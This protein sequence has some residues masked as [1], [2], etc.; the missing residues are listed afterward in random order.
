MNSL[1]ERLHSSDDLP[2]TSLS[3]VLPPPNFE[4]NLLSPS[5]QSVYEPDVLHPAFHR[6]GRS[7]VTSAPSPPVP[8]PLQMIK[9]TPVLLPAPLAPQRPEESALTLTRA[10][11][12]PSTN[13]H[14]PAPTLLSPSLLGRPCK[15]NDYWGFCKGAW[16]IRNDATKGM[17]LTT[18][19]G[20]QG[21][22]NKVSVFQCRHCDF[23]SDPVTIKPYAIDSS[24]YVS[25]AGTMY[26]WIFLAKSH[27]RYNSGGSRLQS[28]SSSSV[29]SASSSSRHSVGAGYRYG[30]LF[31]SEK[32][33]IAVKFNSV[34]DMMAHIVK[35]HGE[36]MG[37]KVVQLRTRCV[38][39][40][41][42]STSEDFD[43]CVPDGAGPGDKKPEPVQA[44]ADL[45]VLK[46]S[47][48]VSDWKS[49]Y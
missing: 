21:P 36:M 6:R 28:S 19:P 14:L 40:R 25:S 46:R 27:I 16:D 49:S 11:S 44:E 30:C 1:P 17:R 37:N 43:I 45:R 3:L 47:M 38:Y 31:C 12:I 42:A 4:P 48:L 24:V 41:L 2:P 26:R 39:G 9:P 33:R 10:L 34:Q 7:S 23:A 22:S 18:R 15:K 13:H 20:P 29:H 5:L 32:A 35:D 8:A